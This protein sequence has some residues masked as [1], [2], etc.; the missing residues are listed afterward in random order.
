MSVP[1][2]LE[3]E[4]KAVIAANGLV[5]PAVDSIE[6]VHHA[7]NMPNEFVVDVTDMQPGDV[8]RLSDIAMP[9][10]RDCG[11]RSRHA[12]VTVLSLQSAEDV[13]AEA[14]GGSRGEAAEG[15]EGEG[16]GCADAP[17]ATPPSGARRRPQRG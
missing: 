10:G 14:E 1:L 15:A 5:D 4:A 8:I 9:D 12:V 11:R 3:G 17:A 6:V 16:R 2:R 13:V 7:G